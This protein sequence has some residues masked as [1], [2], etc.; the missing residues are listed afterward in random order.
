MKSK[1]KHGFTLIEI[2][3][4][5]AILGLLAAIAIPNFVRA[6][7][8]HIRRDCVGKLL[9]IE[10]AKLARGSGTND[11]TVT[12]ESLFPNEKPLQCLAG[13]TYTIGTVTVPV[14]CS[15][16]NGWAPHVIPPP[17]PAAK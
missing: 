10:G 9:R 2:L 13:G 3:I 14:T 7:A 17:T 15:I 6:R 12:L 5:V 8:E 11:G 1:Q 16:T 4:V